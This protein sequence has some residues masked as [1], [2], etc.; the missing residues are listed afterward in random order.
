MN[1]PKYIV[2]SPV[3]NEEQYLPRTIESMAA[4]SVLPAQW[5]LIDDGSTDA[6]PAIIDTAAARH[7]WIRAL[8]R[9]DRGF[10]QAGSGV[11]EAFYEGYGRLSDA[12]PSPQGSITPALC[13]SGLSWD[14]LVKL[15]GDLSF[16]VDYFEQCLNR[17]AANPKLGIG[18]GTIC[19]E[20]DGAW[21]AESKI[22]PAFH[23]RGATKIYRRECWEQIGGLIR[24]PGWDT[25]D[26][27]KANMLGWTTA[28]FTDIKL[29]HHRPTGHAYGLWRDL[30]KNGRA[31][32]V[33]GYHPVF[34]LLKCLRRLIEPPF[35]VGSCALGIGFFTAYLNSLPK[36]ADDQVIAYFRRQQMNRLLGRKSLWS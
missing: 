35:F 17:F 9:K 8:H 1:S 18:G 34:M 22:D 24:A 26:E 29:A 6:T 2:L 14:F 5:M 36:V 21:E 33:A 25:V 13:P 16:G 12:T 32:Y 7:P 20:V 31:N 28:T 4:Q 3:R 15:D 19:S 27:V 11:M 30:I 23:V 10:R